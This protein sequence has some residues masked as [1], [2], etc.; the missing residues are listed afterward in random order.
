M[1]TLE[2]FIQQNEIEVGEA[3]GI[4]FLSEGTL[5]QVYS[6]KNENYSLALK[7]IKDNK[8]LKQI[9]HQEAATLLKYR[10]CLSNI[11]ECYDCQERIMYKF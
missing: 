10:H 5:G 8:Y 3:K 7:C 4:E 9:A 2:E 11:V 6:V 1:S